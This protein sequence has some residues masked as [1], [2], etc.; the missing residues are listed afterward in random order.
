MLGM[1]ALHGVV[2]VLVRKMSGGP[3]LREEPDLKTPIGW[4]MVL[5]QGVLMDSVSGK[6]RWRRLG[7]ACGKFGRPGRPLHR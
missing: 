2:P 6:A 4:K 3:T 5:R 7:F 1:K